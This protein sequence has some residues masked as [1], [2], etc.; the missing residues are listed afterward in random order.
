MPS[1]NKVHNT[2]FGYASAKLCTSNVVVSFIIMNKQGI[3]HIAILLV[4]ILSGDLLLYLLGFTFRWFTYLTI[5]LVYSLAY[6]IAS[7]RSLLK[8]QNQTALLFLLCSLLVLI[9]PFKV[10]YEYYSLY[11]FLLVACLTAWWLKVQVKSALPS[12]LRTSASLLVVISLLVIIIPDTTVFAHLNREYMLWTPDL[13]WKDFRGTPPEN[14]EYTASINSH[15]KW[16]TNKVYNYPAGAAIALMDPEKS[17]KKE[18][19]VGYEPRI[20]ALA[21]KHLLRHEQTHFDLA[22]HFSRLAN[23]KLASHMLL[24]E[25]EAQTMLAQLQKEYEAIEAI[26]D[27]TTRHGADTLQQAKWTEKYCIK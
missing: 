9:I 21:E 20:K 25:A 16:K 19:A 11:F 27:S 12:K 17:Y 2:G 10:V 24:S 7:M 3:K 8:K 4:L 15:I 5:P 13:K 26:Y 23:Q 22:E 6:I 1:H 14:S 18:V